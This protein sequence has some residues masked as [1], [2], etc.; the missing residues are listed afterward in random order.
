MLLF[1]VLA[2][3]FSLEG[4]AEPSVQIIPPGTRRCHPLKKDTVIR[5]LVV[6]ALPLVPLVYTMFS[7]DE[8][9]RRL[10]TVFL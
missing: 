6:I 1:V 4:D 3:P 10:L 2:G 7:L 9:L 8:L 5:F